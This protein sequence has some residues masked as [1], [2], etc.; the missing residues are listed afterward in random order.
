M[1]LFRISRPEGLDHIESV[2]RCSLYVKR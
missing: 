2:I 1:K